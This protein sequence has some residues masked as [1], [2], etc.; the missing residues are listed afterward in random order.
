MSRVGEWRRWQFYNGGRRSHLVGG[1]NGPEIVQTLAEGW[2]SP[3]D[4]VCI[5]FLLLR[6]RCWLLLL[7][8]L[9]SS[10]TAGDPGKELGGRRGQFRNVHPTRGKGGGTGRPLFGLR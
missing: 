6:L 9:F 8:L 4:G 10:E 5:I 7:L 1:L 2:S 3:P